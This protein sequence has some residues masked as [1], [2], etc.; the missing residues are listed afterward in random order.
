MDEITIIPYHK[1]IVRLDEIQECFRAAWREYA[2]KFKGVQESAS[3]LFET[4][5]H[6]VV[7][8][9]DLSDDLFDSVWAG[10][11]VGVFEREFFVAL[12]QHKVVGV[13]GVKLDEASRRVEL[14]RMAVHPA[15][16]RRGI[17]GK[18][19][20][21]C[22]WWA[23]SR[24]ATVLWLTTGQVMRQANELYLSL[25]YTLTKRSHVAQI[26]GGFLISHFELR[27]PKWQRRAAFH[28]RITMYQEKDWL[29]AKVDHW[30][31]GALNLSNRCEFKDVKHPRVQQLLIRHCE[32]L[33]RMRGLRT[34]PI[35]GEVRTLG[36]KWSR[37]DVKISR[38]KA[39]DEAEARLLFAQAWVS[40]AET[41]RQCDPLVCF[42]LEEYRKNALSND[43]HRLLQMHERVWVVRLKREPQRLL[44][45]VALLPGG[46]VKK[47]CVSP[48]TRGMGIARALMETAERYC[49][50]VGY[51]SIFLET[52]SFMPAALRFYHEIGF[53]FEGYLVRDFFV[54]PLALSNF[55]KSLE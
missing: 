44:G 13:V 38:F 51:S 8:T 10:E 20:R 31:V 33:Y 52:G 22:L 41:M 49:Q 42:V 15:Y 6:E 39:S 27:V 47:L 21:S 26:G 50:R 25:G 2:E 48:L 36:S 37:D 40:N 55:R 54:G 53:T 32:D 23:A 11:A 45:M 5:R 43:F 7:D 30:P 16:R 29:V 19:N 35:A 18:L 34:L 3:Q 17:A 12:C 28:N 14:L 24:N 4:Y 1:G 9:G 46:E